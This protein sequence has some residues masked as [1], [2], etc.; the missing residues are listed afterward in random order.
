MPPRP[1]WPRSPD[2]RYFRSQ[3]TCRSPGRGLRVSM[4]LSC[5]GVSRAPDAPGRYPGRTGG[6][7]LCRTLVLSTLSGRHDDISTLAW[8][9][10][11]SRHYSN[12]GTYCDRAS[13]VRFEHLT[14]GSLPDFCLTSRT[15]LACPCPRAREKG[16]SPRG[17]GLQDPFLRRR[18]AHSPHRTQPLTGSPGTL[19]P[20]CREV[21]A[22]QA[23]VHSTPRRHQHPGLLL[24]PRLSSP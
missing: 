2:N 7:W 22:D 24:G 23:R 6:P 9:D 10:T 19:E 15:R 17:K 3:A 8:I 5:A 4:L 13:Y 16:I 11:D 12:S 20:R 18:P 21:S 14:P 1:S